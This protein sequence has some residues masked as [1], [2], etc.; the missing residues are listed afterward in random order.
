MTRF[1][2]VIK[3][4]SQYQKRQWEAVPYEG[5]EFTAA[6]YDKDGEIATITLNRPEKRNALNDKMFEDFLA[7]LHRA[8]DDR[9]VKAVIIKGAGGNFS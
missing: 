3:W 9:E 1:Q 6:L 2:D 8:N 7:A 4:K 5:R